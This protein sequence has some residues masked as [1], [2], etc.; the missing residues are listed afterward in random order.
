MG[1]IH[2][3]YG[4]TKEVKVIVP[5]ETCWETEIDMVPSCSK[6]PE[7]VDIFISPLAKDKIEYLMDKFKDI[8]WLAYLM[9]E[10]TNVEDIYVPKQKVSPGSVTDIDSSICNKIPIIGVIHSHHGMGNGFSGTDNAWIN[11]NNDISL[12]I[13]KEGINGQMRWKT[14]CGS[15]KIVKAIV[16]L[17]IDVEYDRKAFDKMIEEN[18]EKEVY[19]FP[20]SN[21]KY[22]NHGSYYGLYDEDDFYSKNG[23]GDYLDMLDPNQEKTLEDELKY[24][25]ESGMFDDEDVDVKTND[26]QI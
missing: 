8:E 25:E 13:S 22:V 24:L 19:I 12:C 11:Q 21:A 18:I 26:H 6:A 4:K 3:K 14:P 9:G 10:G 23:E 16:K 1:F 7:T 15:L 2:N 20:K 17:K 5:K